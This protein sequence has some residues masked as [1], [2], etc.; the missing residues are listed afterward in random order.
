[1]PS[2][3]NPPSG[4]VFHPRCPRA[5]KICTTA[6][7][8]LVSTG[9]AGARHKMACYFPARSPNGKRTISDR[10]YTDALPE[11]RVLNAPSRAR[12]TRDSMSSSRTPAAIVLAALTVLLRRR[13]RRRRTRRLRQ[14]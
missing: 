9:D 1:M 13:T 10:P 11:P 4:C 8:R 3:A 2:P 6:M 7:P 5:Q 12:V 14:L